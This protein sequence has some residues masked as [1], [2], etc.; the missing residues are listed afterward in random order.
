[1]KI[2]FYTLLVCLLLSAGQ[3]VAKDTTQAWSA[4]AEIQLKA[5][6]ASLRDWSQESPTLEELEARQNDVIALKNRVD[7]CID[8]LSNELSA[9]EER[10]TTLGEAEEN[11]APELKARRQSLNKQKQ[12]VDSELAVCRLLNLGIRDLQN[13][14]KQLRNKLLSQSLTHRGQVVWA[15]LFNLL[16][17]RGIFASDFVIHFKLWPAILGGLIVFLMLVPLARYA[18]KLMSKRYLDVSAALSEKHERLFLVMLAKRLPWAAG[19]GSFSIFFYMADVHLLSALLMSLT[20]SLLLAPLLEFLIC[21]ETDQC[22]AGMPARLLLDIVLIGSAFYFFDLKKILTEDAY[23]VASASYYLVMM[24]VS[25]WLFLLLAKRET[26]HVLH[27]LRT[28]ITAA[29]IT[30]PVAM[31]L[32]YQSLAELLISGVF[33]SLA[34]ILFAWMFVHAGNLFFALFEPDEQIN[35]D[36]GVRKLLGYEGQEPVP[37]LWIGRLLLLL[38]ILG[39]LLY[40]MLL[41]W[42]VPHSEINI[43][44]AYITEGFSIGAINIVPSKIIAGI[45]AF[46][47]L[48]TLAK[49][50]RNQLSERWLHKT[51]LDAGARESIVSL[52]SYA[53]IGLAMVIAL[54]M[55]GFDFQNIAIIA[56]ALSV[57]IGFGLQNIVNNFISG[58]ILLFERPVKPGDWVI[59][60]S[61]EGHVKKISI[62]YTLIETFD[63]ADVMVPNSELISSQVTNW[64]LRDMI[65]R[66]LVPVGVAYGSDVEKVRDILFKVANEHRLVIT[67]DRRVPDPQVMFMNFGESSLDFEVRCFIRN[68]DYRLAVRSD[69]LFA[70]DEEFRKAGIEIPFPQRVLHMSD[71]ASKNQDKFTKTD[72]D[73]E[74]K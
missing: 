70:I 63:R 36:T 21:H 74:S 30:G 27:S 37:G 52:S 46:F 10:F 65:G 44:S 11:E 15:K 48:L 14:H 69:L 64:M 16:K 26:F 43:M 1:M 13:E 73:N 23:I 47:L 68:I 61:T 29:M 67:G 32:G 62:R 19:L 12:N 40:W 28:P 66:V 33:G 2:F 18:S 72:D 42:R 45:L 49:W 20:V 38:V 24:L 60:G 39:G 31:W 71:E 51:R 55:A 17:T 25:L 59:I 54:S 6:Q 56:G 5:W 50:L 41:A 22:R 4:Q 35:A 53:I 34:G 9:L 3:V 58:L 57:G 8:N 7:Q